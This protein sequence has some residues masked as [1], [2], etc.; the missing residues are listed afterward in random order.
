MQGE[1]AGAHVEAAISYLE[2]LGKIMNEND[3]TEQHIFN[4]DTTAFYQKRGHLRL[5]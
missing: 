5:T 3:Y 1:A 2:D 4:V